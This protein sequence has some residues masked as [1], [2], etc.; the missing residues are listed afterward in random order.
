MADPHLE[1]H[2][3]DSAELVPLDGDAVTLGRSA[4]SAIAFPG[5]D[6]MSRAHAVI[7]PG[8][9]GWTVRDAGS[10]NGTS[11]NGRRI[12][13]PHRLRPGDEVVLGASRV[14]FRAEP[15]ADE[16]PDAETPTTMHE[17]PPAVGYLAAEEEW[18]PAPVPVPPPAAAPVRA[19]ASAPAPAP[20]RAEAPALAPPAAAPEQSGRVRGIA[21]AVQVRRVDENRDVLSFRVDRYDDSGNRLGAVAVEF[22]DFRS[23][24]VSDGEEVEVVGRWSRGTLKASRVVNLSTSAEVRGRGAGFKI[25]SVLAIVFIVCF[26]A[27][28]IISIV[29][30]PTVDNPFK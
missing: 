8:A 21:R 2:R 22:K 14:V 5:D 3:G 1:V 18:R 27:F 30:A 26:F 29:T 6:A 4:R 20:E 9:D 16:P 7:E 24:H 13:G 23:G 15:D 25:A 12:D 10:S 19:A 17:T 28:I 11:V